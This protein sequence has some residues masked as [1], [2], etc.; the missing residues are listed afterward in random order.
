MIDS[1]LEQIRANIDDPA[2]YLVFA[3]WLQEQG[4]PWGKLIVLQHELELRPGDS[5]IAAAVDALVKKHKWAP[6]HKPELLR[7]D[8][9][10]G[11]IRDVRVY[12]EY[13]TEDLEKLLGPVLELPMAALIRSCFIF[14]KREYDE[15]EELAV[16]DRLPSGAV[17]ERVRPLMLD[18]EAPTKKRAA[19][20]RSVG[21]DARWVEATHAVPPEIE[22]FSRLSWLSCE[23]VTSLPA[24]LKDLPLERIDIDWC[25]DLRTIPDAV[26]G[27]VSLGYVSMY[28][29][30]ALGLNMGQVNN[31]LG[32]FVRA[33]TPRKQRILEAALMR[34][35]SPKARTEQLLFAT[36]NNLKAVR[37]RALELLAKQV[38][39]PL[40]KQP[41]KEGS[42]VAQFGSLNLDKKTLKKRVESLGAKLT[43]KLTEQTTHVL[44]GEKPKGKQHAIGKLPLLIESHVLSLGKA[45]GR[46]PAGKKSGKKRSK[47]KSTGKRA[48]VLDLE[49]LSLDLRS[50]KDARICAAVQALQEHGA[51]PGELL[52]ELFLVLQNTELEKLGKGRKQA[53]KLFA[54]YAPATLKRVMNNH[55]KTSVLLAGE[56]KQRQRLLA[57]QRGAGKL[58]DM[59]RVARLL[60]EDIGCGLQYMLARGESGEIRW[61]LQQRIKGG[62]IDLVRCELESLPDLSGFDLEAIDASENHLTKFPELGR[63]PA[64]LETIVLRENYLRTLPKDL[65]GLES[66]RRLDLGRNR[67]MS[68]P[69]GVL[70]IAGLEELDLNA[71]SWG[72]A[73][74]TKIPKQIVSLKKLK[75]FKIDNGRQEVKVPPEMAAMTQLERLEVTWQGAS[76][77]PPAALSKLL[78]NCKIS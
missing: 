26:W 65:S 37:A 43:T 40:G 53:K 35:R 47:S 56:T 4:N 62:K 50:A 5:A 36:D 38:K 34:G 23:G 18:G 74:I 76:R 28:D 12:D 24:S 9:R 31:L 10:W 42:V 73:R 70:T 30:H 64:S 72:N 25:G 67:F 55:F 7:L 2:P 44:V 71:D 68:F 3:D 66:L 51:I 33:R 16:L 8:W 69:K 32:G 21:T 29:C 78:P 6:K 41:I 17:V 58:I 48:D 75:V 27:I 14:N 60:I 77:T 46:K 19:L 57:L 59:Q 13:A 63:L 52:P 39:N 54:A 61:A 49:Q 22:R 45:A 15:Q 1:H 20:L 11:F